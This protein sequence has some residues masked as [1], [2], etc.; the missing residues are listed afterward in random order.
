M[1]C[2][3]LLT[4][5]ALLPPPRRL[6]ILGSKVKRSRTRKEPPAAVLQAMQQQRQELPLLQPM[7]SDTAKVGTAAVPTACCTSVLLA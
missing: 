2:S 6:R 3:L 1:G 5:C 4:R 7:P